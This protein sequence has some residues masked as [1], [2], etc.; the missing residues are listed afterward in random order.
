[1]PALATMAVPA[2]SGRVSDVPLG[3]QPGER[4]VADAATSGIGRDVSDTAIAYLPRTAGATV[5]D[6]TSWSS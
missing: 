5:C 6:S 1:M 2:F 3:G 4:D